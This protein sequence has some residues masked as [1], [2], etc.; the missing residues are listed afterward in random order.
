MFNKEDGWYW[1]HKVLAIVA[2]LAAVVV[3]TL[4]Y[5]TLTSKT[6]S[7]TSPKKNTHK[8]T[9]G[10]TACCKKKCSRLQ[11]TTQK[12]YELEGMY[13]HDYIPFNECRSKCRKPS[14]VNMKTQKLPSK[15]EMEACKKDQFG[16]CYDL[17]EPHIMAI[18]AK[19]SSSKNWITCM[20]T[21]GS[22]YSAF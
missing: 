7:I 5:Q 9:G 3:I 8:C 22:K 1:H 14:L 10:N 16:C 20:Q 12:N 13:D 6:K 18:E 15:K 2:I 21:C 19:I 4:A 17:C 11:K